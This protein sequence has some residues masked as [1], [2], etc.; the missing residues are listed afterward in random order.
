M[1]FGPFF[2]GEKVPFLFTIKDVDTVTVVDLTG[3][4]VKVLFRKDKETTNRFTGSGE[5]DGTLSG[6][7]IDGTVTYIMPEAWAS[8]DSGYW[9]CQLELT[10]AGGNV[11]KTEAIRFHVETGLTPS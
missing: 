6:T 11:R 7:P 1:P 5:E 10:P 4:T 2:V 9:Q 8:A 3:F